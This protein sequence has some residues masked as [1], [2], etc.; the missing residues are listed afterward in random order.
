MQ[1][2]TAYPNDSSGRSPLFYVYSPVIAIALISLNLPS[3]HPF[4]S[5]TPEL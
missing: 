2:F 1:C 4:P 3:V 5:I